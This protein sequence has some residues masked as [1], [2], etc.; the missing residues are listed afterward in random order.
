M[1]IAYCPTCVPN[2]VVAAGISGET[3]HWVLTVKHECTLLDVPNDNFAG[4]YPFVDADSVTVTSD[5]ERL[6][7]LNRYIP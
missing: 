7:R 2:V 6:T 3:A 1:K 4:V 5:E